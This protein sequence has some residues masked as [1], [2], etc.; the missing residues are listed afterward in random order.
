MN[1][2]S[3]CTVMFALMFVFGVVA[4]AQTEIRTVE[5]L[6]AVGASQ[7]S[8]EGSYILMNDIVVDNWIPIGGIDGNDGN[9]FA[10]IFDGNGHTVTINSFDL[11]NTCV[12][13]FGLIGEKGT[14]KK[15]RVTGSISYTGGQKILY[16]GGIAGFNNG[17]IACCVSSIDLTCNYVKAQTEKKVKHQFGYENGQ[18][19][20]GIAGINLGVIV[21]CYS[22][23]SIRVLQGQAAG[24]A[25]GNG[26]PVRGGIGVS[27][28][29]GGGGVS[30]NPGAIPLYKS[31]VA[32][33]YSLASV[34]SA[35]DN[36]GRK[37]STFIL[38]G[39]SGIVA[40]NRLE[41]AVMNNCVSLNQLLEVKG[42]MKPKATPFPIFGAAGLAH[43]NSQFYYREDMVIR[44]YDAQDVALKPTKI[45]PKCA[46]AFS[47]TQEE[48]W[49][50]MPDGL[51]T[52]EQRQVLGFPFGED[53]VSPWKWNDQLKRPVLYWENDLSEEAKKL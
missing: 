11:D 31:G 18:F 42:D 15:L 28:G 41:T 6:V 23:G 39:A 24:I 30:V 20:G 2:T 8:M 48:S 36:T 7:N 37:V 34:S 50:R 21:H 49:W 5:E 17:T 26:K 43:E 1:R 16:I 47:S 10:G 19:G 38:G 32:Y 45:S 44:Q 29:P 51:T 22:T 12:G 3:K 25:A 27:V 46:V 4:M 14:V 9:G 35:V 13:L 52:K 33:C 40:T 53:E